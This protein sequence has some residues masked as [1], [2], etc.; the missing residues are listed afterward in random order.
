MITIFF[1]L[2]I[3][4]HGI[5]QKFNYLSPYEYRTVDSSVGGN[6]DDL[7][8]MM[9]SLLFNEFSDGV[10]AFGI[11]VGVGL[12]FYV[13]TTYVIRSTVKGLVGDPVEQYSRL[14]RKKSETRN[15]PQETAAIPSNIFSK[16]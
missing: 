12:F 1:L 13:F 14:E 6:S 16:A 10:V 2:L 4:Q 3:G 11:A 8:L 5:F 7:R 9:D 15:T